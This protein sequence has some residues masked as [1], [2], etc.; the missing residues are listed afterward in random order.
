MYFILLHTQAVS[1]RRIQKKASSKNK[2]THYLPTKHKNN[3]HSNKS[4]SSP[5]M[6]CIVPPSIYTIFIYFCQC[7]HNARLVC[8]KYVF[9][10]ITKYPTPPQYYIILQVHSHC[11]IIFSLYCTAS[12]RQTR[13]VT[14]VCI[15]YIVVYGYD[16]A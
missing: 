10:S 5:S 1:R 14:V 4:F 8:V 2:K 11:R 16:K 13:I 15:I 9:I 7:L 12:K 6:W 3:H